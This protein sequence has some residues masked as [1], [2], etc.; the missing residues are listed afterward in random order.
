MLM[1]ILIVS[2]F[3]T[4]WFLVIKL[5]TM[6]V[7]FRYIYIGKFYISILKTQYSILNKMM[8]EEINNLY[9]NT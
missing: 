8:Y 4:S 9:Y 6:L 2:T 7:Y 3:D 1:D 5:Y